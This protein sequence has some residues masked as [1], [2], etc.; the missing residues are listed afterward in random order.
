MQT[1][2]LIKIIYILQATGND[3]LSEE[4]LNDYLEH[5]ESSGRIK[6]QAEFRSDVPVAFVV[7]RLLE[8]SPYRGVRKR[9][10]TPQLKRVS[11]KDDGCASIK[12]CVAANNES[13]AWNFTRSLVGA[14]WL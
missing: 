8:T 9:I 4:L 7:R 11:A 5:A 14:G 12:K 2:A 3:E 1:N 10:L 13:W 6:A